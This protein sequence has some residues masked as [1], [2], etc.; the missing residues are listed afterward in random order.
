MAHGIQSHFA[1]RERNARRVSLIAAG[2]GLASLALLGLGRL[3]PVQEALNDPV[4]W[5]FEGP[6]QFVLRITLE[7]PPGDA[8][9]LHDLGAVI[10]RPTRRGGSGKPA[11]APAPTADPETHRQ[12]LGP[13]DAPEDLLARA[14]SRRADV[15]VVQSE[16]LVIDKLVRPAY[17]AHAYDNNIEGR[18]AVM[19][20]V[21]TAGRV[22]EVQVQASDDVAGREF[23]AAASDA[24]WRCRFRPYRQRGKVREV[25]ALFRFNFTIY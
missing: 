17:P 11:P 4:R 16:D 8:Q 9:T 22:V 14:F 5:G 19:A 7:Q 23:G 21:D 15:P 6:K 12:G 20:L 1:E 3:T 13:G 25:Y 24:V 10:E 18:V 2:I